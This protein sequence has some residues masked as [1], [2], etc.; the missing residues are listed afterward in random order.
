M[1][2]GTEIQ[3]N[4]DEDAE[5]NENIIEDNYET[6]R[7][8]EF[9]DNQE[10][11][12]KI[13]LSIEPNLLY[14]IFYEDVERNENII[15]DNYEAVRDMEVPN[16]QEDAER[17]ELPIE[18]DPLCNIF[19]EDVEVDFLPGAPNFQNFESTFGMDDCSLHCLNG[20][21]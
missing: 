8:M 11:A 15:R 13:E 16:N 5:R 2:R 17:I 10:D 3:N 20:F 12:E 6:I 18:R 21:P 14:N 9:P 1:I 7:G 4:Q 19:N